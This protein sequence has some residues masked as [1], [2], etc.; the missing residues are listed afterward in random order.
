[1]EAGGLICYGASILE[2][3][4][5]AGT[6]AGRVLA[7]ARPADLPVVLPTKFELIINLKTAK[8]LALTI[9]QNLLATADEVIE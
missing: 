7:G 4:R 6:Y 2:T 8:T 1:M 9:P 5:Q 3:Y